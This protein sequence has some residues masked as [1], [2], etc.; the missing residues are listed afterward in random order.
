MRNETRARV[1]MYNTQRDVLEEA[2]GL[3][4][5]VKIHPKTTM[6]EEIERRNVVSRLRRASADGSDSIQHA[7]VSS[8]TFKIAEVDSPT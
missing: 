1:K 3:Y 6:L 5:G 2:Q 4:D 7:E 8:P